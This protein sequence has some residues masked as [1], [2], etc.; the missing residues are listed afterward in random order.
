M[1]NNDVLGLN[2][3]VAGAL[4]YLLGIITGVIFFVLANENK[5]VKFHAA[6]S[7]I[8]FIAVYLVSVV[9]GWIPLIGG[10]L[11]AAVSLAGFI[12]WIGLMYKAYSGEKFKLPVLGDLAESLSSS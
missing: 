3:N 12:L 10:I 6:Q 11:S 8:V 5:Y 4:S 2:Q 9:S 1:N 7:I